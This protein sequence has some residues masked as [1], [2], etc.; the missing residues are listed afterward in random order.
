[1]LKWQIDKSNKIPLYLQ[2]K[3]SIKSNI[4]TGV[5]QDGQKLPGVNALAK[6][7][8]INFET[9]RKAYKEL[10]K[11]GF[12]FMQRGKGTVVSLHKA[13]VQA[14]SPE[15]SLELE[16]V[17]ILMSVIKKL[18]HAGMDSG[19]IKNT[20]DKAF[21]RISEEHSL[22]TVIFT[23][24]N[25][26][27]VRE[28]SK[29]L[30]NYLNLNVKPVLLKNLRRE[31]QKVLDGEEELTGIITTG[32]HIHEVQNILKDTPINIHV[33]ITQMSPETKQKLDSFKKGTCFGFICR[34]QEVV[35]FFEDLI[36]TELGENVKLSCCF[37]EEESKVKNII[38]SSDV[39]LTSPPV[40]ERI[41][42]FADVRLPVFNVFDK[43][44]PMSLKLIKDKLQETI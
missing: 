3:D 32:F 4:S 26:H 13:P 19:D 15:I 12:I 34:D 36:R 44:D 1:M 8:G 35:S 14:I 10:E 27:Q 21:E 25:L 11:E 37:L 23:E 16:P 17:D 40:Y 2:L 28:I 33:L 30:K 7:L 18:L 31:T 5:V 20:F 39:L 22:Q 43:V 24:C 42:K 41:K 29:L 9:V 38:K 6:D